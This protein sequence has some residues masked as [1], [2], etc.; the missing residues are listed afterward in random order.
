MTPGEQ[1]GGPANAGTA[2]SICAITP[3][4]SVAVLN[5]F[6]KRIEELETAV[7]QLLT[8][9]V[10]AGE[11]SEISQQVGW[12]GNV[13]Y[14]GVPGWTQTEYGTLI[15]PP[16][17]T[18]S[19][20]GFELFNTCTGQYEP[21]QG[22]LMDENGVLQFGFT[23]NGNMCGAKVEEWDS[24]AAVAGGIA[25]YAL[26]SWKSAFGISGTERLSNDMVI[27]SLVLSMPFVLTFTVQTTGVYQVSSNITVQK[28]GAAGASFELFH[29]VL[30]NDASPQALVAVPTGTFDNSS[31]GTG[32][33]NIASSVNGVM[34]L[35][36]GDTIVCR[37]TSFPS[38]STLISVQFSAIRI[39][40]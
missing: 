38:S 7:M 9:N 6:L 30:K 26:V 14:M 36:A 19:S 17:F 22:V 18:L 2:G 28:T 40:A 16:G 23:K 24:A 33:A 10:T 8:A 35:T 4:D 12:V 20:N 29:R 5:N 37:A 21:Y 39:G 27:G 34:I 13:T 32:G 3:S 15:P 25:T 1:T 11:L 31:V